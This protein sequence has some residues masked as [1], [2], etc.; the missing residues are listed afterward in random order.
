MPTDN[1]DNLEFQ[2]SRAGITNP[3]G[4]LLSELKTKVDPETDLAFRR[5]VH[6]AGTD[7]AGALRDWIFL[8]VH[9][10][11]F[12]DIVRDAEKV[13]RD[14]LFGTGPDGVLSKGQS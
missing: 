3:M 10:R 2:F 6:E 13:N 5:L 12:T 1:D 7:V 9:G 4:K 8:K 11:T 14:K